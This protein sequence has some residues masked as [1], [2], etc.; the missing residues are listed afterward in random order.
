L[1]NL[2]DTKNI[3]NSYCGNKRYSKISSS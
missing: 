1:N 3:S 2:L